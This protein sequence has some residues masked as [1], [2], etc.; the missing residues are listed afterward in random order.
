MQQFLTKIY[1]LNIEIVCEGALFHLQAQFKIRARV[2][3]LLALLCIQEAFLVPPVDGAGSWVS[4]L[5][6]HLSCVPDLP[7][8]HH[9]SGTWVAIRTAIWERCSLLLSCTLLSF[10]SVYFS[11]HLVD[12]KNGFT[13]MLCRIWDTY[14]HDIHISLWGASSS[15]KLLHP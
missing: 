4:V 1:S 6:A 14:F 7:Y 5:A 8:L 11:F 3:L 15:S 2:Q 10:T 9:L 13:C 12:I